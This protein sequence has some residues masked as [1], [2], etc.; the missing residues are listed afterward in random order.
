MGG[1]RASF[2]IK[3]AAQSAILTASILGAA[4]AGLAAGFSKRILV[5]NKSPLTDSNGIS[6][7]P[8]HV[9]P[10]LAETR[11]ALRHL[12]PRHFGYRTWRR[13]G[14]ALRCRRRCAIF[15]RVHTQH[16]HPATPLNNKGTPT[17]VVFKHRCV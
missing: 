16:Q 13:G 15:G 2:L 9:D 4:V 17:G 6:H 1:Y 7:T 14:D 8:A 12:R 10:Q 11:G 3:V 5:A